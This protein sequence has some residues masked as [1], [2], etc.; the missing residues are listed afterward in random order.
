MDRCLFLLLN[1]GVRVRYKYIYKS[2]G[3]LGA[4][5][6]GV[7][8]YWERYTGFFWFLDHPPGYYSFRNLCFSFVSV[9]APQHYFLSFPLLCVFFLFL[10]FS[11]SSVF[12]LSRRV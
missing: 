3:G 9:L 4:L 8:D 10:F 1:R 2:S 12:F 7:G 5:D 11:F 6:R